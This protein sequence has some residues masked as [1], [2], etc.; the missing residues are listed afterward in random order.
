MSHDP[1]SRARAHQT[2]QTLAGRTRSRPVVR[3]PRVWVPQLSS[4]G[5]GQPTGAVA[6]STRRADPRDDQLVL[7]RALVAGA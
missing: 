2:W 6:L 4:P 1:A 5:G 7:V 3:S